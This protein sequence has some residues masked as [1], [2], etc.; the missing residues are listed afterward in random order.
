MGKIKICI[1]TKNIMYH[2]YF[3]SKL[4]D[5]RDGYEDVEDAIADAICCILQDKDLDYGKGGILI[6]FFP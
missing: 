1:D 6:E 5:A 2:T 4:V 3:E